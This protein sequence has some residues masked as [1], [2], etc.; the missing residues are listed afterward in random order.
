MP[1]WAQA[2]AQAAEAI[3][4]GFVTQADRQAQ[5][6]AEMSPQGRAA[7]RIERRQEYEAAKG[8]EISRAAAEYEAGMGGRSI[9]SGAAMRVL[10]SGTGVAADEYRKNTEEL[11]AM[12]MELKALGRNLL[13]GRRRSE[14]EASIA[15][16]SVRQLQL[17]EAHT[18]T[19]ESSQ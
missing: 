18:M 14:L 13:A 4:A 19:Q 10:E 2:Q 6:A 8:A 7:A 5:L 17:I 12:R 16:K 3:G 1:E 11:R 9:S 15:E